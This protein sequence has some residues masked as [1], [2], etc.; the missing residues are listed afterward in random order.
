MRFVLISQGQVFTATSDIMFIYTQL[1]NCLQE[2]KG[3]VHIK[4]W[5]KKT[6]RQKLAFPFYYT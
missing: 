1:F 3:T 6:G 5:Y 4:C 2:V